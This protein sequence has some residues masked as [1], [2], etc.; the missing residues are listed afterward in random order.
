MAVD[1]GMELVGDMVADTVLN[2]DSVGV[3]LQ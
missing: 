3:E 1:L 2:R